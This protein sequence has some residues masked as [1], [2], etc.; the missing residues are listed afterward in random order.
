VPG[1]LPAGTRAHVLVVTG[2]AA[3][4]I[5]PGVVGNTSVKETPVIG[6]G[7]IPGLEI[8]IVMVAVPPD[9]IERGENDF[10]MTGGA[11]TFNVAT[12]PTNCGGV[13]AVVIVLVVLVYAPATAA[14]TVTKKSQ[15]LLPAS[16]VKFEIVNVLAPGT[17]VSVPPEQVPTLAAKFGFGTAALTNPAG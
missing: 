13:F 9:G 3:K 10:V 16:I 7:L 12:A 11:I 5:A 4:V 1:V 14:V 2:P 6:S 15:R 17:A 8:T